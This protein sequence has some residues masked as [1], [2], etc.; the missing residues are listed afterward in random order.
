MVDDGPLGGEGCHGRVRSRSA[1]LDL[2]VDA[3]SGRKRPDGLTVL[4]CVETH[5]T[6]SPRPLCTDGG[7]P[8]DSLFESLDEP[9]LAFVTASEPTVQAVNETF[10][11]VD[12]AEGVEPGTSVVDAL[13]EVG[14][15]EAVAGAIDRAAAR[16]E[17]LER[18]ASANSTGCERASVRVVPAVDGEGRGFVLVEAVDV[19]ARADRLETFARTVSH[20]L[21]NPLDVARIR[22]DAAEE[23]GDPV[24]FEKVR[25][26]H[27]RIRRIASDVLFL[28][29]PA[30]SVDAAPVELDAI[31]DAA[32]ETVDTGEATL[33]I[34]DAPGIAADGA[35]LQRLFEN[36]FR[37]AVE[38]AGQDVAV[39]VAATVEGFYVADD[40]PGID[41]SR[42]DSLFDPGHSDNGGTGLGLTVVEQIAE[43]HGWTVE[44]GESE[45]GGARFEFA[46]I[47]RAE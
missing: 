36:L 10:R 42:L 33:V 9:A 3:R 40:G 22:L 16:G 37:N 32:W 19:D 13:V 47:D 46:G 34:E 11:S 30:A 44:P 35:H 26:A 7:G 15:E 6:R 4:G 24:H 28:T 21:R 31:V 8:T 38:H 12:G 39:R 25:D 41:A 27:E 29:E 45:D 43:A 1:G 23:T 18:T 14:V 17:A 2:G 5:V 20:D